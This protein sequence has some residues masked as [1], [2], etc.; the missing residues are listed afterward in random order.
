MDNPECL[1]CTATPRPGR[2]LA[3]LEC[4]HYHCHSCLARY[5]DI[6][7]KSVPFQPVRCCDLVPMTVLRNV[8]AGSGGG[9]GGGRNHTD[10]LRRY[11][12]LLSEYQTNDKLYCHAPACRAFIPLALRSGRSARCREC[13]AKTCRGCGGKLHFGRPCPADSSHLDAGVIRLAA[14][15]GWKNC[16][17]CRAVVEKAGGCNHIRSVPE[18]WV[19]LY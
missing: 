8:S 10:A 11:R 4:S 7:T 18:N 6:S 19:P 5:L 3:R 15:M 12:A 2:R 14:E 1:I 13:G 16:P 17:K 9:G